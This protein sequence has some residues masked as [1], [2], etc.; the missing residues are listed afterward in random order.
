[1]ATVVDPA[2]EEFKPGRYSLVGENTRRAI[3]LG[4]TEAEWYTSPIERHV[5]RELLERRD[6]PPL[7]D[8]IIWVGAL[9]LFGGL[10]YVLWPSPWAVLPFLA[11]SVLF[12][13]TAVAR[14][15]ECGHNTAFRTDW[16]NAVMYQ[17]TSFMIMR[18]PHVAHWS[19]TRHHSDTTIVG[20]D[21]EI[22]IPR[23]PNPRNV[24]KALTGFPQVR[25]YFNKMKRYSLCNLNQ[26][27]LTFV[28]D[29]EHRKIFWTARIH[30]SIYALVILSC[31]YFWSVLPLFYIGLPAILGVWLAPIFSLTQHAGLAENV[32][33]HRLNCRTILM[34]RVSCFHYWNMNYHVEH[35]MFPLV[36]YYNLP[37][38]YEIVKSDM[39][40]PYHGLVEAW[41][42]IIATMRRQLSDPAY[43]VKRK[44]P[45]PTVPHLANV[46]AHTIACRAEADAEG[47]TRVCSTGEL[48][49][50]DVLRFDYAARTYALYRTADGEYYASDGICTHGN[51]HL[52]TGL[53]QGNMIEC[54]KHNGRFDVRDGSPRRAP[55]CSALQTYP[56]RV[57][58]GSVYVNVAQAEHAGITRTTYEFRVVRNEN[59]ATFIKELAL[60]L[61]DDSPRLEYRPGQ[62]MQML[63]P[64]Y[65]HISFENL[66]VGMPYAD[67][68]K[69]QHVFD[70]AA[71]NPTAVRRNLSL[72]G[73]PAVDKV[74][75]RFNVRIATPPRGQDCS[76]GVGSTYIWNLSPGDTIRAV[77]PFGDFL[78]QDTDREMV[79]LGGGSGMAPLRSHLS[80]LF[81]TMKTRRK[82]SY[83]YGARARQELFYQDYFEDLAARFENFSVHMALSEPLPEDEWDSHTGLIHEVL[84]R[85]YLDT[86]PDPT[87]I[88]YYLCGP[89]PMVV[90]ARRM[91]GELGVPPRQIAFDEF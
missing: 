35:H 31:F 68:W 83:W 29:S 48:K 65:E 1:M 18:E 49:R 52:A 9:A 37:R 38:L 87:A 15:H 24:V 5:L 6:G 44:I 74:I 20:R 88:E 30:L 4:L 80:Y 47:W 16:M 79:Y 21:P 59:V 67:V 55:V 33:D 90:A 78:I 17:I 72:A 62:Y 50:E 36:P 14:W 13:S 89:Q 82:V 58:D 40:E 25:N 51:T 19:H 26:A 64:A 8:T 11:Y 53:V 12:R 71:S 7:R 69:A 10:G 86:H 66:K 70:F 22:G 76:A 77:G 57:S 43:F 60:Q 23:P 2:L 73:N 27:E 42:E 81:E 45:T 41:R 85:E 54:A 32:L 63:I 34:N 39:P 3:Q 91:L 56:V 75:L 84:K 28:P 46:A 61:T